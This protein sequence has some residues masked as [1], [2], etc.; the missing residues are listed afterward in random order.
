M[1]FGMQLTDY[2][3]FDA[4]VKKIAT[5]RTAKR[6]QK[7]D[8]QR[9]TQIYLRTE[10]QTLYREEVEAAQNSNA[11]LSPTFFHRQADNM[12]ARAHAMILHLRATGLITVMQ[13][14]KAVTLNTNTLHEV[15]YFLKRISPIPR[16]VDNKPA[17]ARYMENPTLPRLLADSRPLVYAKIRR[18]FPHIKPER[19]L[20]LAALKEILHEAYA[21]QRQASIIQQISQLRNSRQHRDIEKIFDQTVAK[22]L[23]DNALLFKWNIWRAT[24][25]LVDADITP[26]MHFDNRGHPMDVAPHNRPDIVCNCGAF[27]LIIDTSVFSNAFQYEMTGKMAIGHL[28]QHIAAT[29]RPSYAFFIAPIIRKVCIN[30]FFMVQTTNTDADG[31]PLNIIPIPLYVIRKMLRDARRMTYIPQPVHIRNLAEQINATARASHCATEWY[32]KITSLA[33]NWLD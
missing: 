27:D 9:F 4:T 14:E 2:R 25:Q 28:A 5:F 30:H 6:Q 24:I 20:P 13:A 3:L 23:Y 11:K 8:P 21:Q 29:G 12:Q 26:N 32:I 33:L 22:R 10:L 19:T 17:F 16:R 15:D 1:I 18:D 31:G 7:G